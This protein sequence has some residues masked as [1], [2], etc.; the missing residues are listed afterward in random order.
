[1]NAKIAIVFE[2]YLFWFVLENPILDSFWGFAFGMHFGEFRLICIFEDF[3][4]VFIF[5]E[6]PLCVSL[7]RSQNNEYYILHFLSK[8]LVLDFPFTTLSS[9]SRFCVFGSTFLLKSE[10]N[11]IILLGWSTLQLTPGLR[12]FSESIREM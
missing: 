11:L 9:K 2:N 3:H 6:S 8:G 5:W 7:V 12:K 4:I 10:Q 1:M